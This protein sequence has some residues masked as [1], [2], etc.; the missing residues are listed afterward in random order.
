ML[1]KSPLLRILLQMKQEAQLSQL[2]LPFQVLMLY[3]YKMHKLTASCIRRTRTRTLCIRR[4]LCRHVTIGT[5]MV[6]FAVLTVSTIGTE[7]AEY[8]KPN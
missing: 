6:I 4:T 2:A 7:F 8:R 5:P 1:L 3:T